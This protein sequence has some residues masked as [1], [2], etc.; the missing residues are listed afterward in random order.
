MDQNDLQA[1]FGVLILAGVFRSKGESTESLWDA[2]TG[3]EL[4]SA[5]MSLENFHKI[6]RIIRFDN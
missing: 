3:R 2:E 6:S 1:Y 4:F 5:S